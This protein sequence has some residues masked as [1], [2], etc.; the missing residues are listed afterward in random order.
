M[1]NKKAG[2]TIVELVVVIAVIAVLV[3]I[4]AIAYIQVQKDAR[5]AQMQTDLQSLQTAI[6]SAQSNSGKVLG[7]ITG[8]WGTVASCT[9][10][11]SG[12]DFSTLSKTTDA[13]WVAY[14]SAL[15]KISAAGGQDVRGLVDPWG[16]PYYIDENENASGPTDCATLDRL[17][18]FANPFVTGYNQYFPDTRVDVEHSIVSGC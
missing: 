12:T 13:C 16:R 8:S 6:R 18:A 9:T 11:G 4:T 7:A 1:S 14:L 15:D 17:G 2:F 10:K 3:T 5:T